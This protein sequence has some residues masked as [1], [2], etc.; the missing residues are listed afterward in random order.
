M[1][2]K[3]ASNL[4]EGQYG[5]YFLPDAAGATSS[6]R[7]WRPSP[8]RSLWR[9]LMFDVSGSQAHQQGLMQVSPSGGVPCTVQKNRGAV[10]LVQSG[11]NADLAKKCAN[12][13]WTGFL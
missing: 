5:V 6:S 2:D 11:Y 3:H 10:K 12:K 13:Y 7:T 8:S 1:Y 4:N 9:S